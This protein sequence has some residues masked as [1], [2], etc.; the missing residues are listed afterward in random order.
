MYPATMHGLH[1]LIHGLVGALDPGTAGAAIETLADV[2]KLGTLRPDDGF[3]RMPLAEL[4][5]HG[6]EMLIR[7]GLDLGLGEAFLASPAYREYAE[8]RKAAGLA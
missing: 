6:F 2:R 4:T 3:G 1:A 7:K 5:T 8:E